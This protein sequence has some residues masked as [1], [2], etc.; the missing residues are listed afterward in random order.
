MNPYVIAIPF[1][2]LAIVAISLVWGMRG[3]GRLIECPECG[4]KFKRPAFT[5]KHYGAGFSV[6]GLG[7]FTCPKCKFKG[8]ASS[9][10][11][12]DGAVSSGNNSSPGSTK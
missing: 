8:R 4:E 10:K 9:F 7:D 1:A 11:F 2:V 6:A 12:A 5:E 3:R